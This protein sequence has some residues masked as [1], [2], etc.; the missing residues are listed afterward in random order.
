MKRVNFTVNGKGGVGKTLISWVLAQYHQSTE[1]HLY[2][3][4]TD[5]TNAS[6][7]RFTALDVKHILVTDKT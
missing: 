5:P 2:C 3:A 6:F 4:D 7:A 1:R